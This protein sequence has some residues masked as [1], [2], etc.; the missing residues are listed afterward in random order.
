METIDIMTMAHI[1]IKSSMDYDESIYYHKK[2]ILILYD[3]I[4]GELLYHEKNKDSL[5]MEK[6][7]KVFDF[8][9]LIYFNKY[10]KKSTTLK[11]DTKEKMSSGFLIKYF[12]NRYKRN[13]Q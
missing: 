1:L 8:A 9:I 12:K 11:I 3:M 2:M 10:A 5:D 7:V 4:H 13:I 6:I